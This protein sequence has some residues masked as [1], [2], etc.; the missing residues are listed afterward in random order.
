MSDVANQLAGFGEARRDSFCPRCGAH[1]R[2]RLSRCPNT[3]C[4][5][6]QPA[7]VV[8]ASPPARFTVRSEGDERAT[9]FDTAADFLV[10]MESGD[11]APTDQ[12]LYH[13]GKQSATAGRVRVALL[14]EGEDSIAKLFCVPEGH[15]TVA[16]PVASGPS[17]G[18]DA[19]AATGQL[20]GVHGWLRFWVVMR[21]YLDPIFTGLNLIVGWVGYLIL[22]EQY[23]TADSLAGGIIVWGVIDTGV[24]V[25]LIVRGIQVGIALRDIRAGAV[26]SAKQWLVLVLAWRFIAPIPALLLGFPIEYLGPASIKGIAASLI[27]FLIWYSY[28]NVSKRVQATYPDWDAVTRPT[29]KAES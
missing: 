16:A 27:G 21:I 2:Q 15:G 12:V 25:Y 26:Q 4:D 10:A 7:P 14:L 29:V 24:T 3:F 23:G 9:S 18:T 22:A 28:F 5:Y 13:G 1:L 6:V 11:V 20:Y 17:D 19:G 8:V